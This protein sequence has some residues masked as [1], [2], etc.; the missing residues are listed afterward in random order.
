MRFVIAILFAAF[1]L[2][3]H[4]DIVKKLP[5][6]DSLR[7]TAEAIG[8]TLNDNN[9]AGGTTRLW[10]GQLSGK[11]S[12][13]KEDQFKAAVIKG[14]RDAYKANGSEALAKDAAIEVLASEFVDGDG[15]RGTVHAMTAALMES[16]DYETANEELWASQARYLWAVLRK[17]PVN[18][19]TLVGHA[20][21]KITDSDSGD[22]R[23]VQYFLLVNQDGRAVQLFT[24][25]G[26]M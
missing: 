25:Q 2:Q 12:I 4:A 14:L 7:R 20:T 5:A 18:G 1:A 26:S 6:K 23:S 21:T 17:L 10:A 9:I 15:K 13:A 16:N 22:T 11:I 24:V 19:R 3:A 8:T